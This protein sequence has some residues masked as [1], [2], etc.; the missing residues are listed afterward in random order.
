MVTCVQPLRVDPVRI[1]AP[2]GS[3]A[4]AAP[5]AVPWSETAAGTV[6]CAESSVLAAHKRRRANRIAGEKADGTCMFV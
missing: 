4:M 5:P 2:R 6:D 3:F 1:G